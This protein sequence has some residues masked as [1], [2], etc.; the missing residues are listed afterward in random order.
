ML[1]ALDYLRRTSLALQLAHHTHSI[2]AQQDADALPVL[3]QLAE[4]RVRR[5]VLADFERVVASL[6]DDTQLDVSATVTLLLST[7]LDTRCSSS[8]RS[9]RFFYTGCA[10]RTARTQSFSACDSSRC[11]TTTWTPASPYN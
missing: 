6:S 1:C 10:G 5:A 3:V 7:L 11:L 2:C 8:T 4:G 9:G